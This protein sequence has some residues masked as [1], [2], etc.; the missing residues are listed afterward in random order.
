MEAYGYKYN[1]KIPQLITTMKSRNN[2][3]IDKQPNNF[4]NSDFMSILYSKPLRDYRKPKFEIGDRVHISKYE[5]LFR[6]GYKPQ[7]T[8]NI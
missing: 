6:K 2:R 7:Y 4:K 3:S 8:Q 1:R 5:L